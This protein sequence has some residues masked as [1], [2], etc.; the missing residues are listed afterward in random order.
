MPTYLPGSGSININGGDSRAINNIFGPANGVPAQGNNLLAYVGVRWYKAD[1]STGTFSAPVTIP[2]DFYGKGPISPV[3][4]GN[5]TLNGPSGGTS[6]ASFTVP[7]YSV[8]TV[9]LRGGGGGG[10]GG[11]GNL[12]SGDNGTTG[13]TSSFAGGSYGSPATG[14]TGGTHGAASSGPAPSGGPTSDGNPSGGSGGESAYVGYGAGQPGGAGGRSILTLYNP[15]PGNP[16]PYGPPVGSSVTVI[17]G[18]SGPGG[19]GGKGRSPWPWFPY[20]IDNQPPGGNP[21]SNGS[22]YI[23]WS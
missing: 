20:F 7:L 3:T 11:D 2:G 9:T 14:G 6:S 8:M 17:A 4:G 10:G 22:V 19:T 18:G 16:P 12:A 23:E 13:Y 15:V 21:G 5:Y 1:A